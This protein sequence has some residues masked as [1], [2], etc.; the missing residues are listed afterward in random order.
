MFS[1]DDFAR[2]AGQLAGPKGKFILSLND[3]PGVCETFSGFR[4]EAIKTRYSISAKGNQ[5]VGE[6]LITN[7]GSPRERRKRAFRSA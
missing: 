5:A 7:F 6:V 4:I 2:L 1:R 3:T